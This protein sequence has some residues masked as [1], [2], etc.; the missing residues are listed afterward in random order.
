MIKII[1]TR[2]A[3]FV[4]IMLASFFAPW[5]ITAVLL[6]LVALLIES[7]IEY[8][9]ITVG[10]F[11]WGIFTFVFAVFCVLGLFLRDKARFDFRSIYNI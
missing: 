4:G 8:I 10:S 11:G 1:L 2:F 7:P 3:L 9:F 5:Q 6:I